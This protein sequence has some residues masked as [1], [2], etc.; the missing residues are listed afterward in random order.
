ME[1]SKISPSKQ[2]I[3]DPELAEWLQEFKS[4]NTRKV[5]RTGLR[6]FK[7]TLGIDDLGE[8]MKN[9][10][11]V[12]GDVRKFLLSLDGKPSRTIATYAGAV[13]VFFQD[14]GIKIPDEAWKKI[15]R[16]GYM[17]K[18]V[19]AETKD[20]KPTK[21]MLKKILNYADLKA[22]AMTLFLISSGARI[23]E[24]LQLKQEDFDLE[25]DPPKAHIRR[26]YTKGGVGERTVFFS[27]EARDAIKDWLAIKD[28]LK[29]RGL[30]DDYRGDKVFPWAK[31]TARFMWN[32]A[33]DKAGLGVKDKRTKRRVYHLHS[34]RKFFRTKIGLDVDI[35]HA[36]MGH[37]EYLDAAYV[38]LDQDR[39]IAEAYLE[40][41]P[42]V[43]VYEVEDQELKEETEALREENEK[44]KW[45][46]EQ[47]EAG[48][49]ER[50]GETQDLKNR[51]K[52]TEE[53]LNE[54]MSM[55]KES[56]AQ[57]K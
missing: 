2:S 54:V 4:F 53:K 47:L 51:V 38:R 20:K 52:K 46:I 50:N 29:K 57:P 12:T 41:M 33:C 42:N 30:G 48:K 17:P 27:Y 3:L 34:L 7:K 18:R 28:D 13:K 55:L 49:K 8:Y 5:Y 6:K 43:S 10:P 36:L 9:N 21:L 40:A 39:E 16:R 14:K 11:D 44:L 22:R 23:G 25:A 31:T 26:E 35:T 56:L 19:R 15:R 1:E 24:T 32:S 45:R 37:A